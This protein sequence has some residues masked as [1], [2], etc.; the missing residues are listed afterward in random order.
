MNFLDDRQMGCG[1]YMDVVMCMCCRVL[2]Y[3]F[4]QDGSDGYLQTQ[5]IH[6]EPLLPVILGLLEH[7]ILRDSDLGLP[8][9]A[10]FYTSAFEFQV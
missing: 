4:V 5:L 9:W 10:L 6:A 1:S 7:N 8:R 2:I 3:S